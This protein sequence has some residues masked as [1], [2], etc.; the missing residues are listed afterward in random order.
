MEGNLK[1]MPLVSLLEMLHSERK[2]GVLKIKSTPP[3]S[4]YLQAGE[5]VDGGILDWRGFE[6]IAS[7][8]IHTSEGS[9]SFVPGLQSGKVIMP[10]PT[11]LGEW[12]RINDECHR[13]FNLIDSPSRVFESL[14]NRGPYEVFYGGRSVRTAAKQWGVPLVIA[15]ERVW[16]GLRSGELTPVNRYVWYKLRIRHPRA[17]RKSET[18]EDLIKMMDGKQNLGHLVAAGIDPD[19]LRRYLI[20]GIMSGDLVFSGR[21]WLLRDL[22]WE[23]EHRR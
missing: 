16:T 23:L 4:L 15:M 3:L 8:D 6:A 9:F 18:D 10:M 7:Y 1:T 12:A 21:G 19:R 17:R 13:F 2:S 22:L 20:K 5:V 14:E 11:L